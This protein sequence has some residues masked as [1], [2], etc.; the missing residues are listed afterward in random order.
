MLS[1]KADCKSHRLLGQSNAQEA[2]PNRRLAS[3]PIVA[4]ANFG[5]VEATSSFIDRSL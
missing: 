1:A 5:E 4:K 2:T 3:Q